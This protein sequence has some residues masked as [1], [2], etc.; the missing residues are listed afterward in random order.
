MPSELDRRFDEELARV[1][2][3]G[4]R[5]VVGTGRA[6]PRDRREFP[7]DAAGVL[8]RPSARSTPIT[9]PSSPAK[10]GSPSP[11]STG[12]PDALRT[13]L[14]RAASRRA[15][16]SASQCATA[17]RGSSAYM[18]ILKAGGVAT[19]LNGWWEAARNGACDPAHR[20]QADHCRRA[21]GQAHR[22]A[23]RGQR[24]RRHRRSSCPSRRRFAGC[25]DGE[26]TSS[27]PEIAPEDDATIL[28]TS[29]STGEC[30][31][32]A[33]DASR[34]DTGDL[35]LCD[36][37]DRPARAADAGRQR[38][39]P[40]PPRTL[41]SVPLFHVTGE[42]P[43]MLNSFVIGR[44]MVIMP[45]WDATRGAAADREG[46]DHLF[47]RRADDEPGAHDP[48]RPRQI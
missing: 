34:G 31:G 38:T 16:A 25:S 39:P 36:R 14:S 22:R 20:S 29:G 37:P 6:R 17:R 24:R 40:T 32:R 46:E 10:S 15:T 33:V 26:A 1:V 8:P 11:T 3:P 47:R 23:L 42:V 18:A 30:Q 44:C 45:K 9:R 27:S 13:G 7:R 12:F 48:P 5:L 41:L 19:L 21:A 2:G 4:G 35:H 28:F 43:V